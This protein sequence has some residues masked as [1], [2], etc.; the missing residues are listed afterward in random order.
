[1]P[2]RDELYG[3]ADGER[4]CPRL[5]MTVCFHAISSRRCQDRSRAQPCELFH[6]LARSELSLTPLIQ[7]GP[8]QSS[9]F[10]EASRSQKYDGHHGDLAARRFRECSACASGLESERFLQE[11]PPVR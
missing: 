8:T 10:Q 9:R 4:P 6:A 1:M 3:R 7:P 11:G 5:D 2:I